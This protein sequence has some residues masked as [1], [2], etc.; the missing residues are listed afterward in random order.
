MSRKTKSAARSR[1]GALGRKGALGG[2]VGRI[3]GRDIDGLEP[4]GKSS[5]MIPV[6]AK[7]GSQSKV[8]DAAISIN[9]RFM[10]ETTAR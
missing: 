6:A 2:L 4:V 9:G 7:V 8:H 5:S 3:L 1:G 10:H